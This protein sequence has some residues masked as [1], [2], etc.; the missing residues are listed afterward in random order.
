MDA[1]R[2]EVVAGAE[3]AEE[4]EESAGWSKKNKKNTTQ[5]GEKRPRCSRPRFP[6]CAA[7]SFFS[8]LNGRW[9]SRAC[10]IQ[11]FTAA[12]GF[13]GQ[14]EGRFDCKL[15]DQNQWLFGH[16]SRAVWLQFF[17]RTS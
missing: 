9:L 8:R 10:Q 12:Y 1:V 11:I 6:K 3:E 13:V 7:K 17:F 15:H 2:G 14:L 16:A 4:A 5:C